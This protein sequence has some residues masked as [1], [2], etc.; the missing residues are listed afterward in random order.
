MQGNNNS[1]NLDTSANW[2]DWDLAARE[3]ALTDYTRGLLQFRCEHPC[4]RPSEFFT[5]TDHNRNGLKDLTWYL[6]SGEEADQDYFAN[7]DNH[8]LA[9]RIDGTEFGDAAASIYVAYNGWFNP[10]V[11]TLPVNLPDKQWYVVVDTST[12]NQEMQLGAAEYSVAG[13]SLV[14]LIE[15]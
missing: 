4:L 3:S 10:V 2:F 12:E 9:Y 15:N 5:G 13:R 7:P 8:F 6:D 11:A 14:L 1:Y